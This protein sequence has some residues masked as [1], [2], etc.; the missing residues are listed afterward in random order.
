MQYDAWVVGHGLARVTFGL[1]ILR[2]DGSEGATTLVFSSRL[3][4]ATY[5]LVLPH[6]IRYDDGDSY[7]TIRKPPCFYVHY[8]FSN[9]QP[10]PNCTSRQ[11]H[12]VPSR[13]SYY[14]VLD[15]RRRQSIWAVVLV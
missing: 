10:A 11:G 13:A 1:V 5:S 14:L 4:R 3:S 12:T 8:P 7:L 15:F 2:C 9:Q 6:H